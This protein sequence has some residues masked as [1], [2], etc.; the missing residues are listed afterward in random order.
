[1][2]GGIFPGGMLAREGLQTWQVAYPRVNFIP[3]LAIRSHW[4]F[5]EFGAF[6][7]EVVAPMSSIRMKAHWVFWPAGHPGRE[8]GG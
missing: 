6:V 1:M 8:K 5:V 4:A 7:T 2:I 3:S